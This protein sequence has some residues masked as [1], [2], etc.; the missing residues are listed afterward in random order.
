MVLEKLQKL[1]SIE[2]KEASLEVILNCFLDGGIL[3]SRQNLSDDLMLS[4]TL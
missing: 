4:F 1:G 2:L 3:N